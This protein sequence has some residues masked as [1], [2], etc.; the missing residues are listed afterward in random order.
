MMSADAMLCVHDVVLG[1]ELTFLYPAPRVLR[2]DNLSQ[3]KP[4][5]FIIAGSVG[6][7]AKSC[8]LQNN[9]RSPGVDANFFLPLIHC[10]LWPQLARSPVS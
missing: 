4:A 2:P 9:T 8:A 7:L 1:K 3:Q 6:C 5:L 10:V